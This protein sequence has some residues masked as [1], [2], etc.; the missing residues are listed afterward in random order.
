MLD[1]E[2][3]DS[4]ILDE[5]FHGFEISDKEFRGSEILNKEFYDSGPQLEL[6]K[7]LAYYLKPDFD[8]IKKLNNKVLEMYYS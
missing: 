8:I 1:E 5:E 3:H 7:I 4:E 2:F 6:S